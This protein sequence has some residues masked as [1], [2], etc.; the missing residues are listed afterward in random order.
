[1]LIHEG[2]SSFL[3]TLYTLLVEEVIT[4]DGELQ[5]NCIGC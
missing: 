3:K 4:K 2:M 1:M 5:A